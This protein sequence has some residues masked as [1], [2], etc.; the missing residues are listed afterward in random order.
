MIFLETSKLFLT[1]KLIFSTARNLR[2]VH[3][4]AS[5]VIIYLAG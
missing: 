4:G 3:R 2:S 1:C 5:N